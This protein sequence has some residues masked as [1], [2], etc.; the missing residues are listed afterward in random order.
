M[1]PVVVDPADTGTPS[2]PTGP[3]HAVRSLRPME[4]RHAATHRKTR[5]PAWLRVAPDPSPSPGDPAVP[6]ASRAASWE[7]PEEVGDR[8]AHSDSPAPGADLTPAP[9][10]S[11]LLQTTAPHRSWLLL[12]PRL[13][14]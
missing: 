14:P 12:A 11:T 1:S 2:L 3:A 5:A 7:S 9:S 8:S 4:R 6:S 10:S 13:P